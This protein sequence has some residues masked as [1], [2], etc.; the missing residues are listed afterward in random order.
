MFK[1]NFQSFRLAP[2]KS[3]WHRQTQNFKNKQTQNSIECCKFRIE[4]DRVL[5]PDIFRGFESLNL[6][7]VY[8]LTLAQRS[9]FIKR[10]GAG[11]TADP[12]Y[13][14]YRAY[15]TCPSATSRVFQ[16]WDGTLVSSVT[17]NTISTSYEL[18]CEFNNIYPTYFPEASDD[19]IDG[20]LVGSSKDPY[21]TGGEVI[22]DVIDV[23][24]RDQCLSLFYE[25]CAHGHNVN[26]QNPFLS[27]Y[28]YMKVHEYLE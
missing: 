22:L 7:Y 13:T 18:G 14:I 1:E 2:A 25:K 11:F 6:L 27:Y 9:L 15:E 3:H 28:A 17:T 8:D 24:E 26:I 16:V 5:D 10:V 19:I 12:A 23:I 4:S 21:T 20:A